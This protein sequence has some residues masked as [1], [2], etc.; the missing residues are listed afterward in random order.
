MIRKSMRKH[1][2]VFRRS[3]VTICPNGE[4]LSS[5]PSV[6]RWLNFCI[7]I[8]STTDYSGI[9]LQFQR[10][11]LEAV[12]MNADK[13]FSLETFDAD[14]DRR[15]WILWASNQIKN[16]RNPNR[17]NQ[18]AWGQNRFWVCYKTATA[19]TKSDTTSINTHCTKNSCR[20][21][22]PSPVQKEWRWMNFTVILLW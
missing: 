12:A 21:H 19:T 22:M 20:F 3:I 16:H 6:I 11:N 9:V 7:R 14:G 2:E 4:A 8:P 18:I 17:A 10:G 13:S 5:T 15:K 1:N